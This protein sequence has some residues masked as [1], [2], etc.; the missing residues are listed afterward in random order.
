MPVIDDEEEFCP[1]CGEPLVDGQCDSC[2]YDEDLDDDFYD[3]D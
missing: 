3:E 2:G 1:H